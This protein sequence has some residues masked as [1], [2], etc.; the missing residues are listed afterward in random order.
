MNQKQAEKFHFKKQY[1]DE[2]IILV[3]RRHWIILAGQIAVFLILILIPLVIFFVGL[4]LFPEFFEIPYSNL[5]F[6]IIVLYSAFIWLYF[7]TAW[8][9][10]YLDVW[11]ITDK[12]VIDI[13]QKGLFKRIVAEQS[14]DRI[15]DVTAQTTGIAQTL[16]KYGTVHVQTAGEI[17]RFIFEDVPDPYKVKDIVVKAYKNYLQ[18]QGQTPKADKNPPLKSTSLEKDD[19][20]R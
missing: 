17:Q 6:L 1:P 15:Q 4:S 2:K 12:R 7:F 11:I 14:L 8:A 5:F 13:E 3:L 16:L 10:Y 20:K 18:Q 19:T 9:D